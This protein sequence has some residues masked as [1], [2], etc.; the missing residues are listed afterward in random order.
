MFL[1]GFLVCWALSS[2][3]TILAVRYDWLYTERFL[4]LVA[5]PVMVPCF[6]MS[7]IICPWENVVKPVKREHF[8]TACKR[9][10]RYRITSNFYLC[11]DWKAGILYKIFFVRI[12]KGEE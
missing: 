11:T 3:V 1:I 8:E 12:R 5:A 6:V 9:G 7:L 4:Y 2:I 10:K